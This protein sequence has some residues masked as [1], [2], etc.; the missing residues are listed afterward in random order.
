M[1]EIIGIQRMDYTNKND[2]RVTG[3][4]VYFTYDLPP[5]G[6]HNGK[7]A[8]SAFLSDSAFVQSG[9]GVGDPAMPI[10]NKYGKCTGFVESV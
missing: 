10:Y 4:K 2:R 8:D 7:A 1:Y 6:E 9:V 5:G 3:Y